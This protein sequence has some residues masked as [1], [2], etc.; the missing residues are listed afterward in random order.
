[1][2]LY[3]TT[4]VG[5]NSEQPNPDRSLGG[6]K[7][8]TVVVNDDFANLF[9][10]L[11]IMTLKN[12][13]DEYRAII[14]RNDYAQPV[15]NVKV[16]IE[17]PEDALCT[18]KMAIAILNGVNKYNQRYM[19]NVLTGNNKPFHAQFVDMDEGVELEIGRIEP[20]QEIGLWVCRHV[21]KAA[22]KLQYETVCEPDPSDPTGRRY[23]PVTHPKE[24]S[25]NMVFD[26][27]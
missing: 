18:Y 1:M 4:T 8:A 10:E 23:R 7:S 6:Y 19:E 27:V 13:R 2:N 22:A 26:W 15:A 14:V 5:Y 9:D 3:Y 12:G 24:E 16:K 25:I 17:R 21:D 11:S 20:G